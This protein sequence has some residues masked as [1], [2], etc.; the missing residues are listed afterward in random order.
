[1]KHEVLLIDHTANRLLTVPD[2]A[3]ALERLGHYPV[4]AMDCDLATWSL[5]GPSSLPIRVECAADEL[6]GLL[7]AGCPAAIVRLEDDLEAALSRVK[8]LRR[9]DSAIWLKASGASSFGV[10]QLRRCAALIRA[11]DLAGFIYC[12]DGYTEPFALEARIA[13]AIAALG[14]SVEFSPSN[15]FG[16]ATANTLTAV[17]CGV[18]RV[19]TSVGGICCDRSA[20]MEEVL[21]SLSTFYQIGGPQFRQLSGDCAGILAAL[22]LRVP[23]D[24]AVIGTDIFAFESG[25]HAFGIRQNPALYEVID[26]ETV[27]LRRRLVLGKH[28]GRAAV[29]SKLEDMNLPLPDDLIAILT[30][31]VVQLATRQKRSL[32]EQQFQTLAAALLSERGDH[33]AG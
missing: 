8:H 5:T 6:E 29:R 16:L 20:A 22:G 14:C 11:Y 17:R 12:D 24:K 9:K 25:I 1:M 31:Q 7:S 3:A 15:R 2:S 4:T 33:A 28:S 32:T 27:G 23:G 30:E 26:P 19:H 21:L 18:R 13:Q 10:E